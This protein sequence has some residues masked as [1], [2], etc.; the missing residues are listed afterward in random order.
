MSQHHEIGRPE[1]D[2]VPVP[3][4]KLITTSEKT[5]APISISIK[6]L[7]KGEKSLMALTMENPALITSEIPK[8]TLLQTIRRK[9]AKFGKF[10][11]PGFM[12]SVAYIDPGMIVLPV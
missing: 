4:Q 11:G 9:V 3:D 10:V 12:V 8:K 7:A 6:K 5:E 1:S 2:S